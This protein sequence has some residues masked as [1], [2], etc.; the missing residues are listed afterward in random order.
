VTSRTNSFQLFQYDF[1]KIYMIRKDKVGI[2][3][4]RQGK[5]A[6]LKNTEWF[7]DLSYLGS[8]AWFPG[9]ITKVEML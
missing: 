6:S 1:G 2:G 3:L 7:Y 5:M 9:C 8:Q 4:K